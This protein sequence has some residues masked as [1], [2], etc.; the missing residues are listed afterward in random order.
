MVGGDLKILIFPPEG[1]FREHDPVPSELVPRSTE[2]NS[3]L[4]N[5]GSRLEMLSSLSSSI[6]T[7]PALSLGAVVE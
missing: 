5:G 7:C 1:S 4:G 3:S 6:A 2:V